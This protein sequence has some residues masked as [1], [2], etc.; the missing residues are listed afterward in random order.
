MHQRKNKTKKL[1]KGG[2]FSFFTGKKPVAQVKA[3]G[4]EWQS[5]VSEFRG[6]NSIKYN[7]ILTC[8]PTNIDLL[9]TSDQLHSKYHECCPKRFGFKNSSSYCKQIDQKWQKA[10]V[11]ENNARGYYVDEEDEDEEQLYNPE[12]RELHV[13]LPVSGEKQNCNTINLNNI[14]KPETMKML[15]SKCCPRSF[16]FKNSSYFCKSLDSK[17]KSPLGN[18]VSTYRGGK[19]T[20]KRRNRKSRKQ[21]K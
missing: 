8:D 9:K 16:G 3:S 2:F 19:R 6:V 18:I 10:L 14:T 21:K 7:K 5:P 15:Y 12:Q 1:R 13:N 11:D 4:P 17:M 20:Y